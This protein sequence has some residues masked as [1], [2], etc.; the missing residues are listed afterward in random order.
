[1]IIQNKKLDT[2]DPIEASKQTAEHGYLIIEG[3]G[4]TPEE[5]AEWA[6]DYGYHVSP[7]IWCTD[8]EHSE[9]FWRVTT[10]TVDGEN[11]G[12]FAD[13]ELDWHSN[14]VPHC[15]AQEV[16][17]LYAKTIT[18]PTETW[19]CTSIPYWQTL[20]KDM[21]E[22]Y[23]SLSTILWH[24]TEN[25]P[26]NQP[27]KPDWDKKYTDTVIK[28]IRQ[29]RDKSKV[30]LC[31]NIEQQVKEKFNEWRGVADTHK[32]VPNHPL[33]T[34][35]LFFQPYEITNFVKDD[36]ICIDSNEIY[37]TIWNDWI[38]SDK[39]TY[40]HNWKPG[41]IMLMDQTT[42]IHRRP[43]VLKDKPR[44]LLRTANW[45]KGQVRNHFD[46]VL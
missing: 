11:Q 36:Q 12:L 34:K 22:F 13:D 40:K 29:N 42:T 37:Q 25:K 21:Q 3:S 35:G 20:S 23:E 17:G 31:T 4:A 46:Y 19:I 38:C 8:K 45:Y 39:Y 43:D 32:L 24:S 1:M 14:L 27:W 5:Y 28:G 18:Y 6:L 30:Q 16:V 7:N 33:G 26:L 2:I 9:Y 15:D 41:D 44:E 10:D